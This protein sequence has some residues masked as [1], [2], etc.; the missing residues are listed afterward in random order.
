MMES[1][2]LM[3]S[4]LL[5]GKQLLCHLRILFDELLRQLLHLIELLIQTI[6]LHTLMR[7]SL[8]INIERS[9]HT[10]RYCSWSFLKSR[11]NGLL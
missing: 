7:M 9:P 8:A 3:R 1:L 4:P 6:F 11:S 5:G 2:Q 10:S